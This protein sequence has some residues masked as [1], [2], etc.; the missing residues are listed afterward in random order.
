MIF[1]LVGIFLRCGGRLVFGGQ[2]RWTLCEE[3]SACQSRAGVFA[4][5]FTALT[6]SAL[7]GFLSEF[8]HLDQ[9][10]IWGTGFAPWV[11]S[12][13]AQTESDEQMKRM[14]LSRPPKVRFAVCF[15]SLILP[16]N[17]PFGLKT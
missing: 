9:R 2:S 1:W 14:L 17:F 13:I 16:I 3:G 8:R 15:G 6:S 11:L 4:G 5:T 10:S 7:L 12:L